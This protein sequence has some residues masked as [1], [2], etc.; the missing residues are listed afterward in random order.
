MIKDNEMKMQVAIQN[1]KEMM[2]IK[3]K[4]NIMEDVFDELRFVYS[5][6]MSS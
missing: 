2:E 6:Q 1:T 3:H 4:E 5:E